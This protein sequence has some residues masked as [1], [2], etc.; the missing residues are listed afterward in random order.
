M[1]YAD[2]GL[3]VDHKPIAHM[4]QLTLLMSSDR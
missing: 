1:D 2:N 4:L 3:L